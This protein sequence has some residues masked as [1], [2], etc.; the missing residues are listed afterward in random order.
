M[1]LV[2]L[3]PEGLAQVIS[4]AFCTGQVLINRRPISVRAGQQFSHC[5]AGSAGGRQDNNQGEK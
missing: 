2:N 1:I 4:A 3:I 5:S